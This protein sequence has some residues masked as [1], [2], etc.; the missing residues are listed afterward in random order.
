MA[1]KVS[2]F[3]SIYEVVDLGGCRDSFESRDHVA[4]SDQ[5]CR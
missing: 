1:E 3:I 4:M 2:Y 5:T